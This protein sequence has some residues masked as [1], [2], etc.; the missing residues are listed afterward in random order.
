MHLFTRLFNSLM[1]VVTLRYL[2]TFWI[3]LQHIKHFYKDGHRL[4]AS[5]LFTKVVQQYITCL[6]FLFKTIKKGGN[7]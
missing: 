1:F 2:I 6:G 3:L 7:V 5:S 4:I